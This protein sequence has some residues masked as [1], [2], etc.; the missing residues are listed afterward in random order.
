MLVF[1]TLNGFLAVILLVVGFLA[2][3]CEE[4]GIG[5]GAGS[6]GGTMMF[7]CSMAENTSSLSAE[8]SL[9][10][11]DASIILLIGAYVLAIVRPH[12]MPWWD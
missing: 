11:I 2:I 1:L 9:L 8:V 3:L 7:F 5:L 4:A 12:H 10:L 6:L